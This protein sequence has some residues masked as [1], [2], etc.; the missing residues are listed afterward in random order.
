METYEFN[1]TDKEQTGMR[2]DKLLPELNSD[3]SRNQIQ[4]W[5]KAGLVVANDKVVKSNYKVKLNDHIVVTEK[6]VVEADILPE[7]LNLDI[8][9]EDD[10]VAVV[11]KPKGMVVHPSPGHYTNTLVNG[12]M[13]QIKDLSGINGEIR[14]GI[15][16][17]IDMD[18]SGLL[19]VA[20]NDIAHRGLVEQLMDKSVKRKYIALVH[21]NIPHDYGTID[22]PISRNK[23]D[24]QSMAVVD[25]GKEAVTHFNVLEHFKDYTLVECQL[26]TGRTHQIRVHMK[27]IGFPLVGDPKY[28]PKKTLDIGGQA[29]H[30]GL[31]GFEHPVTGEYIERHAELPQDFED[32]LDT[33]RKRDA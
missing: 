16:H 6:E 17:R 18:T 8:Y 10:D 3:W 12:L 11:Y 30:A 31:I 13:Y 4:D 15:V 2:V 23:N 26:E 28:G 32:L 19:M 14:P 9:Y 5:I 27:Y 29:L 33:I 25:D 21:G 7:N 22:A 24:R 1:I 20:K